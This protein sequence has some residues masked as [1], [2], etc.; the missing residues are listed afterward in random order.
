VAEGKFR[1]DLYF[2]LRVVEIVVP[3]LRERRG[4]IPSLVAHILGR[5]C[6]QTGRTVPAVPDRM[7]D[8]LRTY[9]WPGNV[10]ELENALTRA[11]VLAQGVIEPEHL[12][13]GLGG[14]RDTPR[15]EDTP[16]A[17]DPSLGAMELQHVR[18]TLLK[19]GGSK[20]KAAAMLGISRPRLNRLLDKH[21]FPLS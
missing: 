11:A 12:A 8:L 16:H 17:G 5:V 9:D 21:R 13:L 15:G 1:D 7:M 19:A 4:D 2:R 18:R 20:T 6:R 10:R 14:S 3:P